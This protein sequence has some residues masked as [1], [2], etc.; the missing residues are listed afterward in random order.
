MVGQGSVQADT[1]LEKELS[2]PHHD[3]PATEGVWHTKHSLNK[4]DIKVQPHSD[5]HPLMRP[6][7]LIVPL[8]IAKHSD[9][10]V[11]WGHNYSNHYTWYHSLDNLS[12]RF[13]VSHHFLCPC[14]DSHPS[15]G[16]GL[17]FLTSLHV[18]FLIPLTVPL[19]SWKPGYFQYYC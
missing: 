1:V 18:D 14:D 12:E 15:E 11:H 3:L 6:H 19:L 4:G 5:T 10:W 8:S 16:H 2:V 13:T 17:C 7:L 9:L